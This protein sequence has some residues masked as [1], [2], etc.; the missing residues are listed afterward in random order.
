MAKEK[1]WSKL[2]HS[3]KLERITSLWN[4]GLSD[5]QIAAK[6]SASKGQIVGYRHQHLPNVTG[7]TRG[8]PEL[9]SGALPVPHTA[10]PVAMPSDKPVAVAQAAPA[11]IE[12]SPKPKELSMHSP[13]S[14][15]IVKEPAGEPSPGFTGKM[16]SD[17][18]KQ[19]EHHDPED[20]RQ[21]GF[22]FT[23]QRGNEKRCNVHAH[24][25]Q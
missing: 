9:Q 7:A 23:V 13:R 8:K 5:A 11:E 21:C 3:S 22:H 14:H 2:D 10:K 17:W 6:L 4:E 15:G 1:P 19:C 24:E 25:I 12:P 20:G 18:T 16:T